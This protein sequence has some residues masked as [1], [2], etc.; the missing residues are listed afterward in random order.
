MVMAALIIFPVVLRTVIIGGHG[1]F[2][3][4][5][6][7]RTKQ[8][9]VIQTHQL[10]GQHEDSFQWKLPITEIKQILKSRAKKLNNE[11]IVFATWSKVKHMR[12][13]L[14]TVS[15]YAQKT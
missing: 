14:C 15:H 11:C 5:K 13:T 7:L 1:A 2:N 12:Y 3:K 8:T 4:G 9:V 6:Q 10:R